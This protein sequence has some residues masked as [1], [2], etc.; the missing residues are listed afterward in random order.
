MTRTELFAFSA[1]LRSLNGTQIPM[2]YGI[3]GWQRICSPTKYPGRILWKA[4]KSEAILMVGGGSL[5]QTLG[6]LKRCLSFTF[7]TI[8]L[9]HCSFEDVDELRSA[10]H[11]ILESYIYELKL[12]R[13]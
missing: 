3:K 8:I 10:R 7:P 2:F 5:W 1:F 13:G 12:S 9:N 11:G 4:R 6:W